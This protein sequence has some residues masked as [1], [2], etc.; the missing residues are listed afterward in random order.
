MEKT[1]F[2]IHSENAEEFDEIKTFKHFDAGTSIVIAVLPLI[3]SDTVLF[4]TCS[5]H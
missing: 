3:S 5:T 2:N 4:V 1:E